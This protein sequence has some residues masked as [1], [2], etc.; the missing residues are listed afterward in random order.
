[1][2]VV[3]EAILMTISSMFSWRNDIDILVESYS[4]LY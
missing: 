2:Y 1:M 4:N 3:P